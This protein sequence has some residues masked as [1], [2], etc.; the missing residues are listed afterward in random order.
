MFG[1]RLGARP[2]NQTL[3]SRPSGS[4]C[5]VVVWLLASTVALI[6]PWP[7]STVTTPTWPARF[8]EVTAVTGPPVAGV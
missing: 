5:A 1:V 8:V 2:G 3:S 4:Y 6:V 7:G